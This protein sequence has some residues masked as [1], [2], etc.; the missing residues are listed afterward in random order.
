MRD[1]DL[2]LLA[3]VVLGI[4]AA[5]VVGGLNE[6][7]TKKSESVELVCFDGKDVTIP[8]TGIDTEISATAFGN[9]V[10]W[11]IPSES[12]IAAIHWQDAVSTCHIRRG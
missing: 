2:S 9:G 5:A 11:S 10:L 4:A 6:R 1:I 12:G 7:L 8:L 3:G